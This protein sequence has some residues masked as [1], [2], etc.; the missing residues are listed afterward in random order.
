MLAMHPPPFDR[1]YGIV[2]VGAAGCNRAEHI[3][4]ETKRDYF[5]VQAA[6][7]TMELKTAAGWCSPQARAHSA[8][9]PDG[10]TKS[11]SR[12]ETREVGGA[13][14]GV[15]PTLYSVHCSLRV[16]NGR[17]EGGGK[18]PSGRMNPVF[19]AVTKPAFEVLGFVGH[20][21]YCAPASN[22][23]TAWVSSRVSQSSC[24]RYTALS[25][26]RASPGKDKQ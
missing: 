7:R 20:G 22:V 17:G 2:A 19:L 24:R 15:G 8:L 23:A 13:R 21:Q 3:E 11:C 12:I 25:R 16:C 5:I 18:R 4:R 9:M 14:G 26:V 1:L 6:C 10:R